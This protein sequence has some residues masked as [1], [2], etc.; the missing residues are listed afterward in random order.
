MTTRSFDAS[1]NTLPI[2]GDIPILKYLFGT[3]SRN[4]NNATLFVFIK[5]VILRDD[6]FEDLKYLS[7]RST[8]EAGLPGDYP[9]G[10]PI[11]MR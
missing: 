8:H 11:P 4:I 7:S 3:R 5:P 9:R 1:V 2:L 6:K 10:E